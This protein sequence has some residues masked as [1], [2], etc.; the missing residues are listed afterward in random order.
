M[1]SI[2]MLVAIPCSSALLFSPIVYLIVVSAVVV[3]SLKTGPSTSFS[4]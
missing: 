4:G 3:L 1:F 2:L